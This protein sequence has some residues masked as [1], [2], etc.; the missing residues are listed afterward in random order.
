M[1]GPCSFI[2]VFVPLLYFVISHSCCLMFDRTHESMQSLVMHS[3]KIVEPI[4]E[5]GRTKRPC[6]ENASVLMPMFVD[7][8]MVVEF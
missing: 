3:S 8:I 4:R 7:A 2:F 6:M 1:D 5:C